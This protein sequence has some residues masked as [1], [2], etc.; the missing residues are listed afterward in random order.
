M[1]IRTQVGRLAMLL[2]RVGSPALIFLNRIFRGRVGEM[3]S[4]FRFTYLC[5]GRV[6]PFS[7]EPINTAGLPKD[8]EALKSN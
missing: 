3:G 6:R 5:G 7:S 1:N 4:F 2:S 8:R